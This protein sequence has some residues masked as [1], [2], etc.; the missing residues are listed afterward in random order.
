MYARVWY[1]PGGAVKVTY[2]LDGADPG[3]IGAILKKDG[4]LHPGTTQFDDAVDEAELR[5]L[6]PPDRSQRH[7]WRKKAVGRGCEV[8]MTVPDP[9]H[10]HQQALDEINAAPD[11]PTLKVALRRFVRGDT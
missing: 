11:V 3:A 2:L 1:E 10:P 4:H 7:K 8:D 9:P 6:L 5:T